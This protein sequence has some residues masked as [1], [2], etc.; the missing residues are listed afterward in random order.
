MKNFIYDL[1]LFATQTTLLS[2]LAPE[3]KTFYDKKLIKEA[4]PNLVHQQFGQHRPIPAG[5][6]KTIEFRKFT[7]LVKATTPLVEGVTPEGNDLE[8]TS[9][10]VSIDQYGDYVKISDILDLTAIDPIVTETTELIGNQAGLTIDTIVR[11]ALHEGTNVVYCPT[12]GADGEETEVTSRKNLTLTSQLTVDVVQ[13][14]VA[15]LRAANA[16]TIGGK[17]LAVI[18]PH[19]AYSLMRD[20]EWINVHNYAD[21]E[22]IYAGE[23]GEIGGVRFVQTSE[24]KIYKDDTTPSGLAVYG[25]IFMGKDAYGTIDINGGGLEVIVKQLG[26]G[27]DPLNQR[28]SV[29]LK[30]VSA[31]KILIESYLIRVESCVKKFSAKAVAN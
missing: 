28:S 29:G 17:Y 8:V 1:Q 14:V 20:E 11:D 27:D 19:V 7:P 13:Q 21:P 16:P 2:G 30:A 24:A 25:S 5:G 12:I 15:Q 3:N 22:N 6:G 31:A 18:H 26:Y 23:I 10:T 4:S 9:E